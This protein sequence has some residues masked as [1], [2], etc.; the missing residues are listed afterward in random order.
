[1]LDGKPGRAMVSHDEALIIYQRQDEA[2]IH[3]RGVPVDRDRVI[4]G[5]AHWAA[6]TPVPFAPTP[7]SD[8]ALDLYGPHPRG[9]FTHILLSLYDDEEVPGEWEAYA[10]V[11]WVQELPT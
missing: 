4:S 1:M 8:F 7:D 9:G 2:I 11:A 3:V 6:V 10:S 5:L